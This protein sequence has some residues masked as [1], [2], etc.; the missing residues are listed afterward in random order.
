MPKQQEE[1]KKFDSFL[2]EALQL[3]RADL[4]TE[5]EGCPSPQCHMSIETGEDF[6]DVAE[7]EVERAVGGKE[8]AERRVGRIVSLSNL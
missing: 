8:E 3:E 6:F 2:T 5:R 4:R 7:L 1:Q